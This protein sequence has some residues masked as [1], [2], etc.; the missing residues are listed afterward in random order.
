MRTSRLPNREGKETTQK[1]ST[2][3]ETKTTSQTTQPQEV[4]NKNK[5]KKK[6]LTTT[7][8]NIYP[9]MKSS[10]HGNRIKKEIK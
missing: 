8:K 9:K 4:G 5:V 7:S 3:S 1:Q 6:R 2:V 10:M